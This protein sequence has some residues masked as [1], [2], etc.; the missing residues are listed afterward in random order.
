M[1]NDTPTPHRTG[2][3][4]TLL[5]ILSFLVPAVFAFFA[6]GAC[7]VGHGDCRLMVAYPALFPYSAVCAAL[8]P[9]SPVL[10][11][12]LA[13]LQYPAYFVLARRSATNAGPR[14]VWLWLLAAHI[15]AALVAYSF[16]L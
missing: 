12:P 7:G 11:I 2:K 8:L 16:M 1:S 10:F 4:F 15:L 13:L 14:K 9:N 6:I 5:L 3:R